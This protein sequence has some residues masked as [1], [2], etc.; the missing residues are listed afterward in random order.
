MASLARRQSNNSPPSGGFPAR[1]HIDVMWLQ[2]LGVAGAEY[3]HSQVLIVPANECPMADPTNLEL[4]EGVEERR[5]GL[6]M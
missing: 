6:R 1:Q 3:P 5:V 4:G 2:Q